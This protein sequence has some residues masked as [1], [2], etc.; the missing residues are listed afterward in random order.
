MFKNS[1]FYN[2][3]CQT[4]DVEAVEQIM[5]D[6]LKKRNILDYQSFVLKYKKN[7]TENNIVPYYEIAVLFQV[8]FLK[9]FTKF[10]FNRYILKFQFLDLLNHFEYLQNY[11]KNVCSDINMLN[12]NQLLYITKYIYIEEL[13]LED[14][15]FITNE[16]LI[17]CE[18]LKKL[19]ISNNNNITSLEPFEDSLIELIANYNTKLNNSGLQK[20]KSIRR[21]EVNDNPNI[22]SCSPF[23]ETLEELEATRN[24]GIN[25]ES[26]KKCHNIK[27]L[28]G[29]DNNKITT[30]DPFSN[31]II[32]LYAE[33][34]CGIDDN[35]VAKCA[36]LETLVIDENIKITKCDS[37]A[38]SLI[39]LSAVRRFSI[40]LSNADICFG[41]SNQELKKCKSLKKL[42]I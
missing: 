9:E 16:G 41:I 17:Y 12:D 10:I 30:C 22:T 31:S 4:R 35:G 42:N 18:G 26:L 13:N 5:N 8:S 24:S 6:E 32:K 19:N 34:N 14:N 36:K 38:D 28:N 3:L 25:D 7:Y 40:D 39:E 11:I 1:L 29:F 27:I 23:A 2:K 15:P 20:C 37:F 33:G 21:F